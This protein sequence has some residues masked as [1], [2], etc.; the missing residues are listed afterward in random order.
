MPIRNRPRECSFTDVIERNLPDG[1]YV[2]YRVGVIAEYDPPSGDGIHE[3]LWPGHWLISATVLGAG[4]IAADAP[5]DA[6]PVELTVDN[7]LE[8]IVRP[9]REV[10]L[11]LEEL[12]AL[13]ETAIQKVGG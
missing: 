5:A 1:T 11:T 8:E 6:D 10:A 3:P 9:G 4:T 2:L 7:W 12:Q 13:E